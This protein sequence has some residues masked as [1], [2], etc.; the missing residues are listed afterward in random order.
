V[1]SIWCKKS[2]FAAGALSVVIVVEFDKQP[3]WCPDFVN[4]FGVWK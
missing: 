4:K 3:G 2:P 1:T